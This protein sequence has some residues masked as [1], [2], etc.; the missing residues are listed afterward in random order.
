MFSVLLPVYIKENRQNFRMAMES[1]LV[2]QTIKPNQVVVV[3]DGP[4]NPEVYVELTSWISKYPDVVDTV[5]LEKN[6]GLGLALQR[7]LELCRNE[8]TFRMDSDDISEPERFKTQMRYLGEQKIDVVGSSVLEFD[9][10]PSKVTGIREVPVTNEEIKRISRWRNPMNHPSVGFRRSKVLAS[11]G[12]IH[13]PGFEDY[14]LWLRML[15]DDIVFANCS[16]PLVKMRGGLGQASRRSGFSYYQMES[17]FFSQAAR[18]HCISNRIALF[19][20][21][22]KLPIRLLP[23]RTMIEIYQSFLRVRPN[24]STISGANN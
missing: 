11:G 14:Y 5:R 23:P 12:Y 9:V 18:D 24:N 13:M 17:K 22:L 16:E 2:S 7:G 6:L 15:R 20:M 21:F 1:I 4:I 10:E 19:H 8:I 3:Q